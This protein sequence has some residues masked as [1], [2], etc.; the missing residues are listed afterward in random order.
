MVLPSDLTKR[1]LLMTYLPGKSVYQFAW[2]YVP[3][4]FRNRHHREQSSDLKGVMEL[5]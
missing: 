2:K 1:M 4:L 5:E 3:L